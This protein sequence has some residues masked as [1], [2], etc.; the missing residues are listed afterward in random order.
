PRC[1]ARARARPA[2]A[3]APF[4]GA[5]PA[6][7]PLP[8]GAM[9]YVYGRAPQSS[10]YKSCA[11]TVPPSLKPGQS[12]LHRQELWGEMALSARGGDRRRPAMGATSEYLAAVVAPSR[13]AEH[14]EARVEQPLAGRRGR[15]GSGGQGEVRPSGGA[16]HWQSERAAR[17]RAK[18]PFK[19]VSF[20][21]D[22]SEEEDHPTPETSE[23]TEVELVLELLGERRPLKDVE[24][25]PVS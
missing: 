21:S 11:D 15:A 24:K 5:R 7:L 3:R 13:S 8:T 6:P 9:S 14:H 22:S 25:A 12:S 19:K 2:S 17:A 4:R 18:T 10:L 20:G 1:E 16:S 23:K